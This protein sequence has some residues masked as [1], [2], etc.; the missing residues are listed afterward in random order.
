MFTALSGGPFEVGGEGEGVEDFEK[1]F[2]STRKQGENS[3]SISSV[4]C[5]AF[6]LGRKL[7]AMFISEEITFLH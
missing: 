6:R 5:T 7:S 1:M 4:S 3:C 2:C